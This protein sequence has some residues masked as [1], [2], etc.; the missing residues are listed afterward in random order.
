[1]GECEVDTRGGRALYKGRVKESSGGA[2]VGMGGGRYPSRVSPLRSETT[3]HLGGGLSHLWIV[4]II[5]LHYRCL[6]LQTNVVSLQHAHHPPCDASDQMIYLR[7][8]SQLL[9]V[10]WLLTAL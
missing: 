9:W 4:S 6:Y 3:P 5:Y 8:G 7:S 2:R 10:P 1:V